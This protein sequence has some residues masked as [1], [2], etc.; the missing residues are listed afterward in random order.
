MHVGDQGTIYDDSLFLF[1]EMEDVL[2][3]IMAVHEDNFAYCGIKKFH[4][5]VIDNFKQKFSISKVESGI[6]K[7]VGLQEIQTREGVTVNQELYVNTVKQIPWTASCRDQ[8]AAE[9]TS[10]EKSNSSLG[11]Q[12]L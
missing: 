12:M 4:K 3:G 6:F 11:G 9:L 2:S 10:E 1:Y 8:K 5:T 7:Y